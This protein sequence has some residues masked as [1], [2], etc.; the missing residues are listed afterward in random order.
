VE[1][2]QEIGP[3]GSKP[4]VKVKNKKK[5]KYMTVR[6]KARVATLPVGCEKK[7]EEKRGREGFIRGGYEIFFEDRTGFLACR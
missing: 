2:K 6:V 1:S 5:K 4:G 7:R 3:L